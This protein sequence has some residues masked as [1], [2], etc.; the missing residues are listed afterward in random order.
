[1]YSTIISINSI[2]VPNFLLF[3]VLTPRSVL[4]NV[5]QLALKNKHINNPLIFST[6]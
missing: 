2:N 5:C 3:T 4:A 6:C 1:M